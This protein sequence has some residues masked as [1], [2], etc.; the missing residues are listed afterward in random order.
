[1][2]LTNREFTDVSL[3]AYIN[4][5]WPGMVDEIFFA[6]T[7]AANFFRD[8]SPFATGGGDIFHIPD[9]FT[10]SLTVQTAASTYDATEVTTS[11]ATS[12]D[13]TLTI[14]THQYVATIWGD[15]D[16]QQIKSSYNIGEIYNRQSVGL[17][18]DK[19][20]AAIFA[21]QSSV[22]TNTVNDTASVVNDTDLRLVIE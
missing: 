19:L 20:E 14:D 7:V 12:V 4:E 5:V 11:A 22:S 9:A 10:N 2:A 1:M 8:L 18:G 17:L 6:K 13:N 16:A 15:F 3:V 21:L